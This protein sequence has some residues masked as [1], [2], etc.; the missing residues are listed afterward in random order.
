MA[1]ILTKA[2]LNSITNVL[3]TGAT[4][5]FYSVSPAGGETLITT[6]TE[7]FTF[8]GMQ[9]ANRGGDSSDVKV[10]LAGDA[11]ITPAQLK[12][13]GMVIVTGNGITKKYKIAELLQ[14]QQI[15]AGYVL[16]LK[17]LVG[18]AG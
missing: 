16:R 2:I 5:A 6:L 8:A 1:Q 3:Y 18:A 4:I 9:W 10:W 12:I 14:Q 15:G 17:P 7:G 13:S 11:N